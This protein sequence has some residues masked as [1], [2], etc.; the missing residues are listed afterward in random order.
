MVCGVR[1]AAWPH[2][3]HLIATRLGSA[4]VQQHLLDAVG[5]GDPEA[6]GALHG[7]AGSARAAEGTVSGAG[8]QGQGGATS[9]RP[10]SGSQAPPSLTFRLHPPQLQPRPSRFWPRPPL[11]SA[12][13]PSSPR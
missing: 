13:R 1:Q 11:P 8:S 7:C 9:V 6:G 2:R 5:V 4:P 3:A 12:L 10:Q